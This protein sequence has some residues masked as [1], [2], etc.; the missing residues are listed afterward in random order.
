MRSARAMHLQRP[1][2]RIKPGSYH[3]ALFRAGAKAIREAIGAA[4]GR[5]DEAARMLDLNRT[6]LFKVMR[7]HGIEPKRTGRG[8]RGNW[9]E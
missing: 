4:E 1:A 8:K 3:D 5:M 2:G 9:G 6:H 7:H